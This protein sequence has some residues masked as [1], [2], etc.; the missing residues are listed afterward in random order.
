[1]S[2]SLLP[3]LEIC[4]GASPQASV[5]WLHGLGADGHDFAPVIEQ[6]N[7]PQVRFILPHAPSLALTINGGQVMPAWFDLTHS[8]LAA[9]E[10]AAGIHASEQAILRLIARENVR[11]IPANKIVLAG[12]SQGGAIALHTGLHYQQRLAGILA[13]STWLPLQAELTSTSPDT[14]QGLP[15]FIGHGRTDSVVPFIRAQQARDLLIKLGYS[16]TDHDY[17]MAHSVC[18]EEILDIQSWLKSVLN[19]F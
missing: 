16:V 6:L 17:E 18:L 13:L 2:T 15:V 10:D 4:N 14:N 1:M 12:F 9:R 8:D 11:G 5:I 19:T 7:I 3:A